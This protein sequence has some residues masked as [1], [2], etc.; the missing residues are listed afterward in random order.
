[1]DGTQKLPQRLLQP[2]AEALARGEDAETFA[3]AVAGWMRYAMG[4]DREGKP[5]DLRDPRAG[6]IAAL[7]KN[8]DRDGASIARALFSLP[9]LFPAALTTNAAWTGRVERALATH[10]IGAVG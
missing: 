9:G 7:L 2:A 1:M 10:G 4:I 3:I 6:E 5:Y 8:S